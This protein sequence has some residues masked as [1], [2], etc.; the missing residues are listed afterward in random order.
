VLRAL[1]KTAIHP[2]R[3]VAWL[4]FGI[5]VFIVIAPSVDLEPTVLRAGHLTDL[6]PLL[7]VVTCV[8]MVL[9]SLLRQFVGCASLYAREADS[10]WGDLVILVC[11]L[12]C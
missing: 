1:S 10:P 12:R 7:I 9:T 3:A 11:T 6:T 2:K 8:S 4:L 5:V